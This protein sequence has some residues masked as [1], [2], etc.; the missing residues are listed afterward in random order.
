MD[1][2]QQRGFAASVRSSCQHWLRD[3]S[4]SPLFSTCMQSCQCQLEIA[5]RSVAHSGWVAVTIDTG[6]STLPATSGRCTS[7]S[8]HS[9]YAGPGVA[10]NDRSAWLGRLFATQW[11]QWSGTLSAARWEDKSR[12]EGMHE[13]QR[14][15]IA[16]RGW[17]L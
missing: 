7:V 10:A 15:N 4:T 5:V 9:V 3:W 1:L 16:A 14:S 2:L 6:P 12:H 17:S 8:S 13:R 11:S